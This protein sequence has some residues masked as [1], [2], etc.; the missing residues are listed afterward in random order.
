MV[1]WGAD[2]IGGTMSD[3]KISRQDFEQI[4][5]DLREAVETSDPELSEDGTKVYTVDCSNSSVSEADSSNEEL[6]QSESL[7]PS[8][9]VDSND[10]D[11]GG[12]WDIPW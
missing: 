6:Q 4:Y 10:T 9:S 12:G 5:Y 11:S 8:E 2:F 1:I 7:D 3:T